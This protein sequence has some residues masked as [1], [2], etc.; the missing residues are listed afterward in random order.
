[1]F[2]NNKNNLTKRTASRR[3]SRMRYLHEQKAENL[4]KQRRVRVTLRAW[5]SD[6][7][8]FNLSTSVRPRGTRSG[9]LQSKYDES[10]TRRD[11]VSIVINFDAGGR[12]G[13]WYHADNSVPIIATIS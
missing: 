3:Y 12:V 1:M 4:A 9:N 13:D 11:P 5:M 7:D 6:D 2:Q 8:L 10:E